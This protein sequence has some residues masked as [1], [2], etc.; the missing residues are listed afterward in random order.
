MRI[1]SSARIAKAEPRI[2]TLSQFAASEVYK[3]A[4][5][6]QIGE[7]AWMAW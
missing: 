4:L 7:R 3:T 6:N 2:T 5:A 1:I